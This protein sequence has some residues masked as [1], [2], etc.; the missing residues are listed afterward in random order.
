MAGEGLFLVFVD[1]D[2]DGFE[3]DLVGGMTNPAAAFATT[4]LIV[5]F[6]FVVFVVLVAVEE[7]VEEAVEE[8]VEAESL[9]VFAPSRREGDVLGELIGDR[10]F[11]ELTG[12]RTFGD[13][14]FGDIM[15]DLIFGEL[16]G[17]RIFGELIGDR[18][19]GEYASIVLYAI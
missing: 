18:I 6:V 4:G 19:F 13:K 1:D 7:T 9:V 15:G 2:D 14:S 3:D 10:T 17:D 11:G 16:I 5:D 12:D 8:A